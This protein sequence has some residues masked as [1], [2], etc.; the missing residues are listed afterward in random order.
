VRGIGLWLL[1]LAI[2][3]TVSSAAVAQIEPP[4]PRM[5]MDAAMVN[6]W[7]AAGENVALLNGPVAI[8]LDRLKLTAD[9]AVIWISPVNGT[10]PTWHVEIAL[11]GHAKLQ[12]VYQHI[13]RSGPTLFVTAEV[14]GPIRLLA[15]NRV[16]R[17]Q[18]PLPVYQQ[19]AL[20][21]ANAKA[22][23][24]QATPLNPTTGGATTRETPPLNQGEV[25]FH[26]KL[27]EQVPMPDDTVAIALGG[28]VAVSQQRAN[29]DLVELLADKAV[30]F[31]SMHSHQLKQMK[32]LGGIGDK[33]TAVYLE[34]DVRIVFTPALPAKS[35]E[36]RLTADRAYYEFA[37]DRAVMT[38]VVLHT[39]E[40]Q[41][42]VPVVVRANVVR[43]LAQG[44]FDAQ[45]AQLTTSSFA[46]PS[47]AIQTEQAYIRQDTNT[48]T[49][50][51]SAYFQSRD[52]TMRMYGLPIFYLPSAAGTIDKDGFPLR[53]LEFVNDS[54]YGQGFKS[55][56][57]LFEALGKRKP[58]DV[59]ADVEADYYSYRGPLLGLN[60]NYKG[61]LFD[62]GAIGPS[63]FAGDFQSDIMSD[64]GVDQLGAD[65]TNVKP[66][67]DTRGRILWEHQQF[68]PDDWQVQ[69]RTGY[70]SDPTFVEQYYQRDFDQNLPYD[71]S[72]YAKR[73]R[74]TEA[75][76]IL[77][78][79]D[80][81]NFPTNADRQIEQND[82][83]RLPEIDYRRI[84]DSFGDND[85]FSFFSDNSLAGLQF[86][87]S[88]SSLLQQGYGP[89]P[90]PPGIPLSPGIP[91][92]S[93]TGTNSNMTWRGDTRQEVDWPIPLDEIK[94]VPY[95]FGR[96]TG[97]TNSVN[98]TDQQRVYGGAG[99]RFTTDFWAVD[100]YASSDLL[101]LH[102]LRH[103]IEPEVNIYT[104]AESTDRDKLLIYDPNVDAISDVSAAQLAL[105]QR[106]ETYRG[107]P[108]GWR[109][110]DVLDVNVAANLYAHQPPAEYL[111]PIAFRGL[112]FPSAPETSVPRNGINGDYTWRLSDTTCLLGDASWNMD[113]RELATESIG[114]AVNRGDRVTYYLGQSYI[115]SYV[116]PST[117]LRQYQQ[118]L[119]DLLSAYVS[120]ELTTKY[121]L[122]LGESYDMGP[123]HDV[124]STFTL[125]RKFDRYEVAASIYHDDLNRNNGF[126]VTFIPEGMN[127]ALGAN[128]L[129]A[130]R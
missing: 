100:D 22:G 119:S 123:S 97:Y 106:W 47:Y 112:F 76:T 6:T 66:P 93:Y 129:V 130:P 67:N 125:I 74:D 101:D 36:Q 30:L 78:Q 33:V 56:W 43:Q 50:A 70:V 25:E 110:V 88:H 96:A 15:L 35:A 11:I 54:N 28:Q 49:G 23:P 64:H 48:E 58:D 108:D 99:V 102:R 77:A 79:T 128:S 61:N 121:T 65:R 103:V 80:T 13:N 3:L 2:W 115:E 16:A 104:S 26:A 1:G 10:T 75:L 31:T 59:D 81:T 60:G 17:N 29:G 51:V 122:Q 107:G 127:K 39:I 14:R 114:L 27:L 20:M 4:C 21:R 63:S 124:T 7:L 109:S 86:E 69:I 55:D 111:E 91:S 9:Q 32:E 89:G 71:A 62:E 73:Q 45:K 41:S 82:I 118:P 19:A 34:G 105:H 5:I 53:N 87:P 57:G 116:A 37:T 38:D 83:R 85:Q 94:M 120:Y 68:L 42:Q 24:T 92:D 44:E 117:A 40:P 113:Q 72:F 84:G 46:I 52:D 95:G 18:T 90:T 98:G 8:D 12:Q 126:N